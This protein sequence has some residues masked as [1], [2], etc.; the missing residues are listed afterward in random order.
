MSKTVS[1]APD[2]PPEEK[3]R[4]RRSRKRANGEGT[5]SQRKDGRYEAKVFMPTTAGTVKRVSVYGR[6]REECHAKYV[7]LKANAQQNVPVAAKSQTVA[8]YLSYWLDEVARPSLRP[9]TFRSYELSV[10][11][12]IAPGLGKKK[13]DKLQPRDVRTWLN[14]VRVTCQCCAQGKDANRP[15]QHKDP[16][17]QQRCCALGRCCKEYPSQR[18]VQYL[19]AILRSALQHAVREEGLFQNVAKKV[20]V[21][22]GE[23]KEIEPLSLDEAKRLL[24]A[25]R[26]DRLYALYAVALGIGLRRGEALGLRWEDVDLADGVLQVRQTLQRTKDGLVFLPP[27]TARSR[28]VIALPKTL[29]TALKEHKSRQEAEEDAAGERWTESGLV[30]TTAIG[31]PIE[32]RNL[33]RHFNGLCEAAGIRRVRLHDLRH[34]CATL[35]LAQ[36]VDG[37]TIMELLGHSAIAVTMNIYTHVR[38][39]VLRSAVDRMDG[40]LGDGDEGS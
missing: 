17:K 13:L 38:L 12:Y 1:A 15:K 21:S 5:I 26:D 7:E 37:R 27:K 34:T 29:V 22:A 16:A 32:P 3:G 10:R 40:V 18:S 36:G 20:R 35:L 19:H 11:L 33:N 25:A 31:T 23:R 4:K 6:T 2:E 14:Q 8:E 9:A 30:F 39:D 28:R 24:R